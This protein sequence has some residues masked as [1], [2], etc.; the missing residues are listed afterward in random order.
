M[1]YR[2]KRENKQDYCKDCAMVLNR[3]NKKNNK[4][5]N[6][7]ITDSTSEHNSIHASLEK[8]AFD[9]VIKNVILFDKESCTYKTNN[10]ILLLEESIGFEHIAIKQMKNKNKSR[11]DVDTSSEIFRNIKV[12]IPL[13]ASNMSTV[14]NGNFLSKILNLGAFG[15]LHRAQDETK[16]IHEVQTLAKNHE[17][18]P[19]SIGIGDTQYDFAKQLINAGGNVLLIDIA[20]GYSDEVIDLGRKLKTEYPHI[21]MVVGNTSNTDMME[22]VND[23][24]DAVKVGIAQGLAC[25]TKNTAGCTE[26]QFSCNMKFKDISRKLG[27]PFISDGGIRE[28]ADFTKAIGSGANSVM[29]GSI[30]AACPESAADL[31]MIDDKPKKLYAG[32]AS[33]YVQTLWKGGL[34]A[35]TCAEGGVRYLDVGPSIEKLLELYQGA[36]RTGI[37]YGGGTNVLS[38]QDSVQFV[39]IAK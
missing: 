18:V 36:L 6:L 14:I 31:V 13:I 2:S 12:N 8:I 33:E 10:Q 39:R 16:Y 35:G 28:P 7:Q 30:F 25:E 32:M 27:L 11:L 3:G 34:K 29:A 23:F 15:F 20:H 1:K 19:V 21:K 37:T 26:K 9:L 17:Y 4:L 22:E 38:F 5:E 24:A